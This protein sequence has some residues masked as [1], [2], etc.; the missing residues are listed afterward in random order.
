MRHS[1]EAYVLGWFY[2]SCWTMICK[3]SNGWEAIWAC[4]IGILV[5]GAAEFIISVFE[6]EGWG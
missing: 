1:L 5:A 2:C 4:I 6:S 3:V